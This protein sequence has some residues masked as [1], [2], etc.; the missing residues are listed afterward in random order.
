[1]KTLVIGFNGE[2][3]GK[4]ILQEAIVDLGHE[5]HLVDEQSS[6]ISLDVCCYLED[7]G[8][9]LLVS[10]NYLA[11][12]YSLCLQAFT[13]RSAILL[14]EDNKTFYEI[15]Q[16]ADENEQSL[17]DAWVDSLI[18]IAQEQVS[19]LALIEL[20]QATFEKPQQV[21]SPEEYQQI[22]ID[23]NQTD[24]PYPQD[25]TLQQL[26]EAQVEKTPDNIALVFEDEQLSYRE[27][28]QR[29]NQLARVIR[30]LYQHS[31]SKPLAPDTLIA[32]YLDRSLEMVISILAVLKAGGAY[33]PIA[34]E[35]P[36][37]RTLFMLEDTEAALVITQKQYLTR[38]DDWLQDSVV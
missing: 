22:V 25:K 32:L 9:K 4:E 31:Q 29:A 3:S 35:Y 28:N 21:L 1:M 8:D 27:L 11:E 17:I 6:P 5:V 23:W 14:S 38:W 36:K 19:T 2:F 24:A 37:E 33:V 26:F 15:A 12:T 7:Q 10:S 18:V 20:P 13:D 30:E 16:V 34:P